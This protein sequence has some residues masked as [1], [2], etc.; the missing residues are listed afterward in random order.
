M[1]ACQL[2]VVF[3]L[4]APVVALFPSVSAEPEVTAATPVRSVQ[5]L[6]R[7]CIRW[8][9][10]PPH[11]LCKVSAEVAAMAVLMFPDQ[12]HSPRSMAAQLDWVSVGSAGKG[13]MP[14]M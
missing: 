3:L 1:E 10:I 6:M 8:E 11:F 4:R 12:F 2:P 14:V 5:Q 13:V 9:M 7:I